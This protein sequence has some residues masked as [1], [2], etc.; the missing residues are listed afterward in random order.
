MDAITSEPNPPGQIQHY[1]LVF[2]SYNYLDQQA[3]IYERGPSFTSPATQQSTPSS[4]TYPASTARYETINRPYPQA[5]I[6]GYDRPNEEHYGQIVVQ[7]PDNSA[8][9]TYTYHPT[10]HPQNSPY[11]NQQVD[12]NHQ[13]WAISPSAEESSPIQ[14][15]PPA[16][17]S[18]NP[19]YPHY[20]YTTTTAYPSSTINP[21]SEYSNQQFRSSAD[22]VAGCTCRTMSEIRSIPKT[23][24]PSTSIDGQAFSVHPVHHCPQ[25]SFFSVPRSQRTPL[26][27][28]PFLRGGPDGYYRHHHLLPL[29]M[30]PEDRQ[31]NPQRKPTAAELI[32]THT[33]A[34][35]HDLQATQAVPSSSE[36]SVT[37]PPE[38][39]HPSGSSGDPVSQMETGSSAPAQSESPYRASSEALISNSLR[40][41]TRGRSSSL[42]SSDSHHTSP[43]HDTQ[44]GDMP[45]SSSFEHLV[46]YPDIRRKKVDMACH[47][48]RA[49][50]LKC[51][52]EHPTCN[53]CSKR[54]QTCK[55]DESVR[56]RGPGQ[57]IKTKD[58]ESKRGGKAA[59]RERTKRGSIYAQ[60]SQF[61]NEE[62]EASGSQEAGSRS[63]P[64]GSSHDD[65][66]DRRSVESEGHDDPPTLPE[67]GSQEAIQPYG[68]APIHSSDSMSS[69]GR[70]HAPMQI[71]IPQSPVRPDGRYTAVEGVSINS[72][73]P[74]SPYSSY[75]RAGGTDASAMYSYQQPQV[76]S[77][78][79][80]LRPIGRNWTP[81]NPTY[82]MTPSSL[83]GAM[84]DPMESAE[85]DGTRATWP[86]DR[87]QQSQ[88]QHEPHTSYQQ[89]DSRTSAD[90]HGAELYGVAYGPEGAQH[91][92]AGTY[93][94]PSQ[95]RAP[96]VTDA[97]ALR[98]E[99]AAS[100]PGEYA[101]QTR[102][103]E[104]QRE[105]G[106]IPYGVAGSSAPPMVPTATSTLSRDAPRLHWSK[107]CISTSEGGDGRSKY[108]FSYY[109]VD[110]I[111]SG[112]GIVSPL[113][114]AGSSAPPQPICTSVDWNYRLCACRVPDGIGVWG[115]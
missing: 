13:G 50:K 20:Q 4:T 22:F 80:A 30:I 23:R 33:T 34:E 28:T 97:E 83:A 52:G 38:Q 59:D 95:Q 79:Y 86:V 61:L 65:E 84:T 73:A 114:R 75:D 70:I 27:D 9:P 67:S 47:F 110:L 21:T 16:T 72:S 6:H 48:C 32:T 54:Q 109:T 24:R 43:R 108:L 102:R 69:Q 40:R 82:S 88:H 5:S 37:N 44:S 35:D 113:G 71:Q 89:Y 99:Y 101:V 96:T 26:I 29:E 53:H 19:Q 45:S 18:F 93:L 103:D 104:L 42:R 1:P 74:Y 12:H 66:A 77:P 100:R 49:R 39:A 58:G 31:P 68:S 112:R 90:Q 106:Q 36:Y 94:D 98:H 62:A 46:V 87:V 64:G 105:M 51:D 63:R 2:N 15:L 41:P 25:S 7:G 57:K 60:S 8:G 78:S 17:Y 11:K 91:T 56:R 55:Y 81:S 92:A 76:P 10:V 111:A 107:R 85:G 115:G 14:Q 3:Y